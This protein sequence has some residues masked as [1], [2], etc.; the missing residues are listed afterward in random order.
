MEQFS[1]N[2]KV[3]YYI[4]YNALRNFY[5]VSYIFSFKGK[6]YKAPFTMYPQFKRS[7]KAIANVI[8]ELIEKT[9]FKFVFEYRIKRIGKILK[10][11]GLFNYAKTTKSNH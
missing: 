1:K 11:R 6:T 8:E 9:K 5:N 3:R 7:T 10:K 4:N 2:A